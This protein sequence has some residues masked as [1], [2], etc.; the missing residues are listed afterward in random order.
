MNELHTK[1]NSAIYEPYGFELTNYLIEEESQ[2]YGACR[3]EINGLIVVSRNAK[4]TPTKIGQFVTIWK[5]TEDGPIA[6]FDYADPIDL[7]IINVQKGDELGQFVFPKSVLCQKGIFSTTAKEGKRGIRVYP[8]WDEPKSKQAC[9]TQHWQ[10]Q[11]FLTVDESG[12]TDQ[13][14]VTKLYAS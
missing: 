13:T 1:I 6:P 4:I 7:I 9:A 3:F 14:L 10:L 5:R 11:Y 8:S 12:S 2:E